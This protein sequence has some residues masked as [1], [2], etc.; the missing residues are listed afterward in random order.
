MLKPQL[1]EA[2][3][4]KLAAAFVTE[5]EPSFLPEFELLHARS[6]EEA[7]TS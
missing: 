1:P 5:E 2:S 3:A 4:D 6:G 7:A